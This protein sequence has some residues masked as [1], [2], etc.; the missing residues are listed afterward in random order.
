MEDEPFY[1]NS[2]ES[3]VLHGNKSE[4]NKIRNLLNQ[5]ISQNE[6]LERKFDE[7]GD[8]Q[9]KLLRVLESKDKVISGLRKEMK[10]SMEDENSC[11]TNILLK[12]IKCQF[13]GSVFRVLK[14]KKI[15]LG[16]LAIKEK[17]FSTDKSI[18]FGC[19]LAKRI[20]EKNTEQL[21]YKK[22]L[23]YFVN[24]LQDH[25]K[26]KEK[27][28]KKEQ[29][30]SFKS[31]VNMSI[32]FW[33]RIMNNNKLYEVNNAFMRI[34][35]FDE[36]K[37]YKKN[38]KTIIDDKIKSI[39]Q[40]YKVNLKTKVKKKTS[41]YVLKKVFESKLQKNCQH[42]FYKVKLSNLLRLCE[43]KWE[44]RYREIDAINKAKMEFFETKNK[45]M[46]KNY[47]TSKSEI[48]RLRQENIKNTAKIE[49]LRLDIEKKDQDLLQR[50]NDL[51]SKNTDIK[52]LATELDHFKKENNSLKSLSDTNTKKSMDQ[53]KR[54]AT[55]IKKLTDD[56]KVQN[57]E[58]H[59]LVEK[60]K[61]FSGSTD[62][63]KNEYE[64]I[65][66]QNQNLQKDLKDRDNFIKE[67]DSKMNNQKSEYDSLRK[68]FDRFKKLYE[69]AKAD[70][71]KKSIESSKLEM[72]FKNYQKYHDKSKSDT[73]GQTAELIRMNEEK[74]EWIK[75]NEE[76]A[77]ELNNIKASH[78]RLGPKLKK[79]NDLEKEISI[80]NSDIKKLKDVNDTYKIKLAENSIVDD[81]KLNIDKEIKEELVSYKKM[82]ENLNREKVNLMKD[83][84]LLHDKWQHEQKDSNKYKNIAKE[85]QNEVERI[86]SQMDVFVVALEQQKSMNKN[87]MANKSN[88]QSELNLTA[89]HTR[90]NSQNT[91]AKNM[92]S[93]LNTTT[94]K[95]SKNTNILSNNSGHGE[96]QKNQ[97]QSLIS[98]KMNFTVTED[99]DEDMEQ[100]IKKIRA[101]YDI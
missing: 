45:D 14:N 95:S 67:K 20:L 51:K 25:H 55:Y 33:E 78:A 3:S 2:K 9:R 1:D 27:V 13:L 49:E 97:D 77:K 22:K 94:A 65:A 57:S 10:N 59:E 82:V 92:S 7:T 6:A 54:L 99:T 15:S 39:E 30:A 73:E 50:V 4:I 83:M 12:Y 42:F 91:T 41:L 80:K 71:E 61:E 68:E 8:K 44:G 86:Q 43:K 11:K 26:Q 38:E 96:L 48:E 74:V 19:N 21:D 88:K 89:S 17:K 23:R 5:Q 66:I 31:C 98:D 18:Y 100:K 46:M 52:K 85:S 90:T 76:L 32:Q 62:T 35:I 53:E 101:K 87:L 47:D 28:F 72:K 29:H 69:T 37:N 84:T 93:I 79:V 34:K 60:L 81:E 63:L 16:F 56:H 64:K 75:N 24:L 70:F 58:K 36:V 40:D